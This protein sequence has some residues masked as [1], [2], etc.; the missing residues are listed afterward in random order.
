ME[1]SIISLVETTRGFVTALTIAVLFW[2]ASK[3]MP[4]I[5]RLVESWRKRKNPD[6]YIT[7]DN[8]VIEKEFDY[9][10]QNRF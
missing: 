10:K 3:L 4:G 2:G 9:D 5:S 7:Y 1:E 6:I 8:C